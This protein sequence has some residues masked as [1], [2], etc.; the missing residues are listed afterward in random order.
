[1]LNDGRVRRIIR[2]ELRQEIGCGADDWFASG[3]EVPVEDLILR[4]R[5]ELGRRLAAL[6]REDRFEDGSAIVRRGH[7]GEPGIF[8]NRVSRNPISEDHTGIYEDTFHRMIREEVEA[9]LNEQ[10]FLSNLAAGAAGAV[11]G[12]VQGAVSGVQS[13][14]ITGALRGA[15][16]GAT[17]GAQSGVAANQAVAKAAADLKAAAAQ[18]NAPTLMAKMDENALSMYLMDWGGLPNNPS[19]VARALWALLRLLTIQREKFQPNLYA[20][21]GNATAEIPAVGAFGNAL[22]AASGIRPGDPRW[23][24]TF[25]D[26]LVRNKVV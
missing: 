11:K 14:G 26:A 2:E 8:L 25:A 15:T 21:A 9:E 24:A 12:A 23:K 19:G 17:Q 5:P 20:T 13:G 1:M 16:G 7:G 10:G 4:V 3:E 6:D 22:V 18:G